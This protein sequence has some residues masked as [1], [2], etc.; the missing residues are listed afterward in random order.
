MNDTER[1]SFAVLVHL[2]GTHRGQ[3]QA[4]TGGA[5]LVGTSEDA[6]VRFARGT[7]GVAPRHATLIR[8][9]DRWVLWA[10]PQEAVFVDGEPIEEHRLQ[11]GDLVRVGHGG[12][13][14]RYRVQDAS[15]GEYK[16][17]AQALQDCVDCAMN[18][19]DR[20]LGRVGLLVRAVPRELLT[21]TAPAARILA[22]GIAA[23]LLIAVIALG[24][25][26]AFLERRLDEEAR[27]RVRD[28]PKP[29]KPEK[30]TRRDPRRRPRAGSAPP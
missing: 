25:Y 30:Q 24:L 29:E 12:P 13:L 27:S 23:A 11:A 22:G 17:L 2:T 28:V 15:P 19:S 10:E 9:G 3:R 18:G 16:T 20:S 21:Q 6:E 4:L 26:T 7:A 8:E 5:V 1:A 14:L